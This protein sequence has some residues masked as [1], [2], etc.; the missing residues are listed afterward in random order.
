MKAKILIRPKQGILDPQGKAIE[1]ALP[2]LG[3]EGVS[4]VRVGPPGRARG[5][6]AGPARGAV[7]EAA[8]ESADRGLR[9]R[10]RRRRGRGWVR[11]GLIGGA[12]QDGRRPCSACCSSRAAAMS[13]MRSSPAG[14][15]A[16]R[17]WSG[18]QDA[19]PERH[20][21]V[22]DSRRLLLRRLSAGGRDRPVRA[23]DGGC[24]APRG[25]RGARCSGSATAFRS[26]ARRGSCPAPC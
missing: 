12:A 1:R 20:R 11:A 21:R 8:R 26:S 14:G 17:D 19:D 22:R 2:A 18:T 5:T 15:S 7:R 10:A 4:G 9:D 23:G 3:F 6:D 13:E 16:T 25:R 24:G